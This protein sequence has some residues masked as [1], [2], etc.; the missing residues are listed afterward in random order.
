VLLRCSGQ[1]RVVG[2]SVIGLELAAM[3]GIGQALGHNR[4]ALAELLPAGEAG[5]AAAIR[6][7]EMVARRGRE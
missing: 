3:L 1:L 6:E 2:S 4:R 7:Q 5:L